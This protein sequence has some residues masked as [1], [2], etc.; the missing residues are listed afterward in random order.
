MN[1]SENSLQNFFQNTNSATD[2][3]DYLKEA[4]KKYFD[5]EP[6]LADVDYDR[7]KKTFHD[8]FPDHEYFK[9]VGHAISSKNKI[10]LPMPMGSLDQVYT[11]EE[12]AK[13]LKK[14]N[15]TSL[16]ISD[17]LD[18]MSACVKFE[19]GKFVAGYSRGDGTEGADITK[20]LQHVTS[21]PKTIN[22]LGN[23]LIRGELI[24]KNSI[25]D[26]LYKN[27]F[28]NARNMVSGIF[29]RKKSSTEYLNNV[30]FVVYE[31]MDGVDGISKK[32]Q[33][34]EFL[35]NAGFEVVNYELIEK[36]LQN[37][38]LDNTILTR[39][40]NSPYALDGIVIS[41]D[42]KLAEHFSD[43]SSLNPEHS[44][45]YKVTSEADILQTEVIE[46]EWN[47]SK[48]GFFKPRVRIVPV[49]LFGTTVEYATAFN[50]GMVE[51]LGI[52][53][54]AVIKI[55][56]AGNVI[57]YIVDVVKK[58][59]D[60]M[61]TNTPA[62][63]K[64]NE[65]HVELMLAD[66][67]NN[68]EV[69]FQQVL[70]FCNS[71]DIENL[72][73]GSLRSIFTSLELYALPYE[74]I[75]SI[76]FNMLEVEFRRIIGENGSKIFKSLERTKQ[77]LSFERFLGALKYF[78]TSFGERKFKNIIEQLDKPADIWSISYEKAIT[79]FGVDVKTANAL[80][81]GIEAAHNLCTKLEISLKTELKTSEFKNFS[82]VMTGFRDQEFQEK[83]EKMGA[84]FSNSV[85]KNTTHLLVAD[86]NSNSGKAKKAKELGIPTLTLDEFKDSYP[87]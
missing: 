24:Y 14:Y 66:A 3:I 19:N 5:G 12:Y 41:N 30:S 84:K 38:D 40:K 49:N 10:T 67:D 26:N 60:K 53:A 69:K 64:W 34:L 22:I 21:F 2:Y 4:D 55:T 51:S 25:F 23:V 68:D 47:L 11:S 17:K 58:A 83:L 6:I 33:E 1:T 36:E 45:K 74:E 31:I 63:I 77:N 48:N 76:I 82:I 65:S 54:G 16:V 80:L 39:K 7:L 62:N 13:W 8:L 81:E 32:I 43:S 29:N 57:P 35:K 18:G 85:S 78:G 59:S 15:I 50:A 37:I 79:L 61:I 86:K 71:L 73:E 46:V 42:N 20:H 52:G 72:K 75:I 56:K 27:E 44:V 70:Y 87:F 9:E 28:A